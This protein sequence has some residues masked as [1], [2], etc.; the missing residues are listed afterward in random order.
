MMLLLGVEGGA[1]VV[2]VV[3]VVRVLG[4]ALVGRSVDHQLEAVPRRRQL[5]QV[6]LGVGAADVLLHRPVPLLLLQTFWL[7]LSGR[8]RK[9]VHGGIGEA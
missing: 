1:A 7:A 8:D 6:V 3:G 5:G 4:G 9:I 2:V